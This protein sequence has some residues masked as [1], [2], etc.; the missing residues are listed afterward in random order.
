M[1]SIK[2]CALGH[3]RMQD[4]IRRPYDPSHRPPMSLKFALW[5]IHTVR[6]CTEGHLCR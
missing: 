6:M 3:L 1:L 5:T 2:I 4:F